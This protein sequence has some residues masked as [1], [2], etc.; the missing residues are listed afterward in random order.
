LPFYKIFFGYKS[1]RKGQKAM[2]V[3]PS[4]FCPGLSQKMKGG[5]NKDSK[6]EN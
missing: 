1:E 6:T 3:S 2:P 5:D 4:T